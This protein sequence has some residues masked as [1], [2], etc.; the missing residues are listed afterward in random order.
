MIIAGIECNPGPKKKRQS[1]T[2]RVKREK[3]KQMK[4]QL[5]KKSQ[6]IST[7]DKNIQ[8]H[9]K[10][11]SSDDNCQIPVKKKKYDN[12]K[13]S[14]QNH[15]SKFDN[16]K[17]EAM[18]KIDRDR[19]KNERANLSINKKTQIKQKESFNRRKKRVSLSTHE[20]FLINSRETCSRRK[21]RQG[22]SAL[23]KEEIKK[24]EK[25][26]K[27]CNRNIMSKTKKKA[28]NS[29]ETSSRRSKRQKLSS[30]E[31]QKISIRETIGRKS[32]RQKLSSPEKQKISNRETIGRR[33]KRQKLSSPEKQK[34][35]NR[36]TIR[37]RSKRL[38]LS[39]PEK[40][41]ISNRETIGR[42]N[43]RMK[44]P[45]KK[46]EDKIESTR[47]KQKAKRSQIKDQQ[48]NIIY[49]KQKFEEAIKE[50]PTYICTSCNRLLYRKSVKCFSLKRYHT[51]QNSILNVCRTK[52]MS[53]NSKEY[54]C[55]TC[56]KSLKSNK[57]PSQSVG[58]GL[59]LDDIPEE[60]YDICP[61]EERLISKRLPFMQIVNL[62]RGGQRG[63]KGCVV[64]VPSNLSTVTNILP[65]IPSNCGL[66]PI[67]L[68]RKL[69]YKGHSMYQAIRPE[70]VLTA[71]QCLK[72]INKNYKNIQEDD[73]WI[74]HT[75]DITEK[76]YNDIFEWEYDNDLA[77]TYKHTNSK[78]KKQKCHQIKAHDDI[79]KKSDNKGIDD[80]DDDDDDDDNDLDDDDDDN[81][82]DA[83]RGLP[84]NT[85]LQ[86]IN[87]SNCKNQ[88]IYSVAPGE[89]Q[90]PL[91]MITDKSS[92]ILA[93]PREFPT[94]NFGLNHLD[95]PTK[96][97]PKRYFNQRLLNKD[98]R[99]A[100]NVEYIFFAQY[101]TEVKQLRDNISIALRK[102][103]TNENN[104]K[105]GK[106]QNSENIENLLNQNEGFTFLQSIRGSYPYWC[107]T[108]HDLFA[109]VRQLD[110]PTFF[111]TFSAADL[112]WPETIQI[113]GKQY[114]KTFSEEDVIN[115]SWQERCQ[116][117]RRN[118][119][120]VAR[121]FEH[122]TNIFI[123]DV[124]RSPAAPIG[125][126]EDF[127]IRVEF[128]Q[129]GSPHIHCLFWIKDAPKIGE[130]TEQEV[131][132]FIDKY[133]FCKS[134]SENDLI[135]LQKHSHSA[136]C[137]KKDTSCRFSFPRPPSPKTLIVKPTQSTC[138][139]PLEQVNRKAIHRLIL[140]KIY[141]TLDIDTTLTLKEILEKCNLTQETYIQ[142]LKETTSKTT[143]ILKREPTDCFINNYNQDLLSVWKANMDIQFV[144]DPWA[145]AMYI[146]SY[147]SKGERE[148]GRLLKEASKESENNDKIRYQL[149]K[150]G[151]VFLTH[152]EVS[153][154]EA[155]YRLLSMPMKKCSR[156][157]VFINTSLPSERIHI[158]KCRQ[159]LQELDPDSDDVFQKGLL[160]RYAARPKSLDNM[161]LAD[162]GSLYQSNYG[163]SKEVENLSE[164]ISD[165][166]A[167][168]NLKSIKL[169]N[170]MGIM[171]RR[172]NRA[173][174]R[175]PRFS[176]E[177]HP[178]KFF[179]SILMLY[180]PWRNE[181]KDLLIPYSSYLEHYQRKQDEII[182][183][184][185][186][187]EKETGL[188]DSAL[189]IL[190]SEEVN[191]NEWDR[192]SS[193]T[194]QEQTD[195]KLEGTTWAE[196]FQINA[197]SSEMLQNPPELQN[198]PELPYRLEKQ[199]K[200][201]NFV[202]YSKLVQSLNNEQR[203]IFN[204]IQ[205]WCRNLRR[206]NKTK[207]ISEP[208]HLFVTGGAGTGKSHLINAVVHMARR[209]LQTLCEDNPE[210]TTVLLMA[211]TGCAAKNI[212][213]NTI[214]SALSIPVDN[215]HNSNLLP[216]S[217]NRLASMR[218]HL[219]NLKL[220]I[221]DEISMVG[222]SLLNNIHLRLQDIMGTT[223]SSSYFGGMSVLAVGDFYQLQP[224]GNKHLFCSPTY[225]LHKL[226]LHLWKD[227]FKLG[228]LTQVMRQKSDLEFANMLNR[229][230]IGVPS[231]DDLK[232]LQKRVILPNEDSYPTEALHVFPLN[233]QVD[234]HNLKLLQSLEKPTYFL[235]A[236]SSQTDVTTG[237]VNLP[238]NQKNKQDN[239]ED[240]LAIAVGARVMLI[241][242]VDLS[243][244]LVNG[245]IGT[246][247]GFIRDAKQDE[248]KFILVKFDDPYVGQQRRRK[249][250]I[251]S[252]GSTPI[253]REQV[254]FTIKKNSKVEQIKTQFPL[255][256]AFA[257][258]IHK[259]QGI[260]TEK[261][262]VS[263]DGPYRPGQAYVALSRN[264]NM[265]GLHLTSFDKKKI[266]TSSMVQA[267]MNRLRSQMPMIKSR[268][269]EDFDSNNFFKISHLNIRSL[270]CHLKDLQ[271][272]M[273]LL[274]SHVICLSETWLSATDKND[275]LQ[276]PGFYLHRRDREN[277]YKSHACSNGV[278]KKCNEK[279]GVLI[280]IKN[281]IKSKL[282][283]NF[284]NAMVEILGV[285]LFCEDMSPLVVIS[286][287]RP[288]HVQINT[289]L[290]TIGKTLDKYQ[291]Q[292][293]ICT[294]LGDFNIDF[295]KHSPCINKFCTE[296]KLKQLIS[297]PTHVSG[298]LLDHIY[299]DTEIK[300]VYSGTVSTYYSDHDAVYCCLQLKTTHL[301]EKK[302]LCIQDDVENRKSI[303]KKV[304]NNLMNSSI[305]TKKGCCLQVSQMVQEK[306]DDVREDVLITEENQYP[307]CVVELNT[308]SLSKKEQIA[309]K[310]KVHYQSEE[311]NN[312]TLNN[313]RY[314]EI[315]HNLQSVSPNVTI[316]AT[317]PD[318]NCFFRAISK[319]I[320]GSEC[321]HKIIR[322]H[323]C[324][325]LQNHSSA[326]KTWMDSGADLFDQHV[327]TM[328]KNRTWA[329]QLEILAASTL[330]NCHIYIFTNSYI[331]NHSHS[332]KWIKFPPQEITNTDNTFHLDG[333]IYLHHTWGTHYD[334]V[335]SI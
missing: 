266:K 90:I 55:N 299:I 22:L 218:F 156:Q 175:F 286:V 193:S 54:I 246:V 77:E 62:P 269:L 155:V 101:Y 185:E 145:C 233:K 112:R 30:P 238:A 328:R 114:G 206:S 322:K 50:G 204:I 234:E 130:N 149:K 84:F 174:I 205:K 147:I 146:L 69:K 129:R 132:V 71:L 23:N 334:R 131:S 302:I 38:K 273:N 256:L 152:R 327:N 199:E 14:T 34:I 251:S 323:I 194:Q 47:C 326:F 184:M 115:M 259:T 254:T 158:L 106:L 91:D 93:F 18:K 143:I 128:Q 190:R 110:I 102:G 172:K 64:N 226:S 113:V 70:N 213:G 68:K 229:I 335:I 284:D 215:R 12:N 182:K 224:V 35:S 138:E 96:L 313:F 13:S 212:K 29:R 318:G 241:R 189:Q 274:S 319:E 250:H 169:M 171:K 283:V 164:E 173:V 39:S 120:T 140:N 201:F 161:F 186:T 197:C 170:G 236:K 163:N 73:E 253:Q 117:I 177:K 144:T 281:S 104:R 108:L 135:N 41:K 180:I 36:E 308:T 98:S 136:S 280:Y 242:N 196:D 67:K 320:L 272:D 42:R 306:N 179:H 168:K 208:F 28:I 240:V 141:E 49:I 282:L 100:N 243:D 7:E 19:K 25:E 237:R 303:K 270:K 291:F 230:R 5:R 200:I 89:G 227:L 63:I 244:S 232:I 304:T 216:L 210:G 61:L 331:Q 33:S 309:R 124:I 198:E 279:G 94:G 44:L 203:Q 60:L 262:V 109:M 51:T 329:T 76:I 159:Q 126:V 139:N 10:R 125:K 267:E 301:P 228:E 119:V 261:I 268:T 1:I 116:W 137:K 288:N 118:P 305:K 235:H 165:D 57:I 43:L 265:N 255:S 15:T 187:Y 231:D 207:T 217:A 166:E 58:N 276:I 8:L 264:K 88:D 293:N 333:N 74:N 181:E 321:Y 249:M 222:Y 314:K 278:C 271:N 31:K 260:T 178:E 9:G 65:R 324:D 3:N 220:V 223:D 99:F 310:L 46:K 153:A 66:V 219:Q 6:E 4:Q 245:V 247:T 315:I 87:E 290:S 154:Q 105:A 300:T 225:A 121:Q 97:Y 72:K 316:D 85:C 59:K 298:S 150:L 52:S 26:G 192:I 294:I 317:D 176:K 157:V 195:S 275:H 257:C 17:K 214:H 191:F 330:F 92:E 292:E 107:K 82:D 2:K 81:D 78:N 209:E 188:L 86:P 80:D 183:N 211:P 24:R 21:K 151:N 20:I 160:D 239:L 123:K 45:E 252:D 142:A 37:R 83:L 56:D 122:R 295:L 40:Q 133:I 79:S 311:I 167:D 134:D 202:E 48:K 103:S 287:Y 95:R 297:I 53:P 332:W 325:F 289:M 162:F 263:F 258:T 221:I 248:I 32:K 307:L 277:S 296:K 285:K 312:P 111:C 75:K 16:D 127:F 27:K 11:K 148:M